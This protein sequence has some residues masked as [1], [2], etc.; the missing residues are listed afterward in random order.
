VAGHDDPGH[1]LRGTGILNNELSI[2][3]RVWNR[4]HYGKDPMSGRRRSRLNPPELWI[5]EEV[6]H[7]RIVDD[8][9]WDTVKERLPRGGQPSAS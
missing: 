1:V 6:P 3:K 9:L 5:V 8:E 4:L 2:G 7:L